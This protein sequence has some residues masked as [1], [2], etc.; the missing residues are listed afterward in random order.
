MK[1][2]VSAATLTFLLWLLPLSAQA[3]E[4]LVPVG[5]IVGVQ[6]KTDTVTVVAFDDR[7]GKAARSAGLR[8]GDEILEINGRPVSDPEDIRSALSESPNRVRLSLRRGAKTSTVEL[9]PQATSEG[10]RLGVFLRQG[11][12]GI[13]TVTFYDPDTGCFGALGHGV[14]T[15]KGDPLLMTSGSAY[16]AQIVSVSKGRSGHPGQLKG[17]ASS[18]GV[19]GTLERNTPQGLFGKT[20]Q[21][22]NG[23]AIPAAKPGELSPGAATILSTVSG[24]TPQEYSVE[25]VKVY[26]GSRPDGRNMLIKVTDP[27]L[28]HTTGGIVQGMSGSPIIQNGRLVGAITHVLV[29]DPTMGYGIFIQNMLNA[30]A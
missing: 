3:A 29:N 7:L 30:A 12:S 11:I 28:L 2:L 6:L 15:A 26:P 9:L 17:S 27:D 25:I 22:W 23:N 18:D 8:I 1:K 19:W 4:L 21:C 5:R 16:S 24:T 10:P 20:N 14:N 13:G